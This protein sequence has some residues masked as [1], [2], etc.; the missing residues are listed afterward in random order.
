MADK[1]VKVYCFGN[2]LVKEDS[3]PLEIIPE[4]KK[5][6]PNIDFIP[7]ES[8][9]DIEDENEI[10]IIDMVDGIENVSLIT[11]MDAIC[12]NRRCSMHDFDLGM[13]LKIMKKMG[14]IR[15]IN[16][17]AIPIHCKK[18]EAIREIEKLLSEALT[19]LDS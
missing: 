5:K 10:N 4:L 9:D 7:A 6:F 18:R 3:L 2:P 16:I 14:R 15:K 19:P 12:D 13:T 8:P 11:D 17:F 1:R